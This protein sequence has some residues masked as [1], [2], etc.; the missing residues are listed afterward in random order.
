MK[1]LFKQRLFSWFDSYDIYDETGNAFFTVEGKLDW[2]HRLEI[3]DRNRNH[4]GTVKE[5]V[6]TWLPRF[7]MY[8]SDQY[9]GQI[10]KE[11]SFFR[12]V[13]SLDCNG[14]VVEG[15]W[16]QWEYQVKDPGGQLVMTAS[17]E[18]LNWTDTYVIDVANPQDALLAVMI[19]LA[20]DAVKCSQK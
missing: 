12:P 14:W 13:F 5:R 19:V 16:F 17:K 4:L 11:F 3:Y 9:A 20:I 15:D 18:L 7:E 2:G 6:L 1:L 10:T 8:I